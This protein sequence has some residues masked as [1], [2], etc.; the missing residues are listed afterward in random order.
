MPRLIEDYGLI[1]DLHTAALVSRQGTIEWLCVPRFDSDSVFAAL[2]GTSDNGSWSLAP[3]ADVRASSRSYRRDSLVLETTME[4][5][6]G[7]VKVIDFMPRREDAPTVVRIVEGVAGSVEMR[8]RVACR[9]AFGSLPPWT[10]HLGD[11]ITMTIGSDALAVRASIPLEIEP[12]D[13]R[14]LFTVRAGEKVTFVLQWFPSHYPPPE[15]VDAHELLAQ[16]ESKWREWTKTC[17]CEGR[18]RESVTRSL[19]TLKA[20]M[21][22]PTGGSVAAVTTSIPEDP[23]SDSNWDYRFSWIRDSAFTIDALVGG[24]Y[25]EEALA[26]RD[27]LLR[28]LGGEPGRLQIMYSVGGDRRLAEYE[29]DWLSGFENS[30]PVRIGN[31]AHTQ[32]QLGIYGHLMQAIYTAHEK[33]GIQ[34]DTEAWAMLS[35]LI[36]HVC[37]VWKLPDSGIWEY[38]QK[39]AYYTVSRVMAW[40]AMNYAVRAVEE[41]YDGPI[42]RWRA[43][44]DEI[45]D[46]VCER[47]FHRQ[48][49]AFVQSYG[50]ESIDASVLL[51]PITGFLPADD[52]RVVQTI[53]TIEEELMIDGFVMRDSRHVARDPSGNRRPTEGAFLACNMWLVQNYVFAGRLD[54]ARNLLARVLA[55]ANDIGLFA[56]EFDVRIGSMVGNFPQTFSHATFV[57]AALTLLDAEAKVKH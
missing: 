47:A 11:A 8:T 31:A 4:C 13:V 52:P 35:K 57:N 1:G 33:A 6:G 32:F 27:W 51:I 2:L 12:P 23:G 14:A 21:Y 53:A 44:R 16:T 22:E 3:V 7:T 37:E 36:E 56:E 46:E 39:P 19:I 25:H 43:V 26:W 24:G 10:R 40:V 55:V 54:D 9:F 45:H 50:S 30:K 20:L 34:I 41:G 28:M 29:A 18:F 49:R 38:R 48:R 17:P 15:A 42:E 5:D